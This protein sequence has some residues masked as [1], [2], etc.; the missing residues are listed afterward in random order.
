M[1]FLDADALKTD[2]AGMAFLRAAIGTVPEGNAPATVPGPA[3]RRRKIVPS[4]QHD[5]TPDGQDRRCAPAA[6]GV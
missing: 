6:A 2:P 1:P 3:Q 5:E 4:P